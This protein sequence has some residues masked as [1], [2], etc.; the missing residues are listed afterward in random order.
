MCVSGVYKLILGRKIFCLI[1][2]KYDKAAINLSH[3]KGVVFCYHAFLTKMKNAYNLRR[4]IKIAQ[5]IRE[6]VCVC[7]FLL[8]L[9]LELFVI[10]SFISFS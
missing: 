1:L 2:R 9:F 4:Q 6:C 5:Q 8:N 7:L 10:L 3:V